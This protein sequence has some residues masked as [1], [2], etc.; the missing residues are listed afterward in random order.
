MYKEIFE[1]HIS[2]IKSE[3]R[4]RNF[5]DLTRISGEFPFAISNSLGKKIL[6]WCI[7]DY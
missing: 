2:G 7:N 3:G 5:V 6:L 4:Y 1:T